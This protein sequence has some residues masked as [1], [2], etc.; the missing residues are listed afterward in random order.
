MLITIKLI[1]KSILWQNDNNFIRP[2]KHEIDY[3]SGYKIKTQLK[4][5]PK[6]SL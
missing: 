2:K 1:S 3:I 6:L 4:E 5:I